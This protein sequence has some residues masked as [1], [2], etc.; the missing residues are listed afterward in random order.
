MAEQTNRLRSPANWAL[1][2]S[3]LITGELGG[4]VCVRRE[5][6]SYGVSGDDLEVGIRLGTVIVRREQIICGW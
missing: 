5:R 6:K 2:G 4:S 1:F 3:L